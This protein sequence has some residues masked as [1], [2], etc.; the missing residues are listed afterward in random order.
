MTQ[1]FLMQNNCIL[2]LDG[3]QSIYDL[4]KWIQNEQLDPQWPKLNQEQ[5]NYRVVY[6]REEILDL[7]QYQKRRKRKQQ[8]VPI[9]IF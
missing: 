9:S 1:Y 8:P 2:R 4:P 5:A 7:Q 3:N 6:F